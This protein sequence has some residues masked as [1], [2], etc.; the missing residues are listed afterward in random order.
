MGKRSLCNYGSVKISSPAFLDGGWIPSEYTQD[1]TNTVVPLD[2]T[3]IPATAQSLAITMHDPDVPR[4]KYPDDIFDHWV[5]WNI[6]V[7]R[8]H[9]RNDE[10]GG[11]T[12]RSTAGTNAW[13]GPGPPAGH[14]PHR[15]FFTAYALDTAL[16][17]EMM[18][19]TRAALEQAIH[20]NVLDKAVLIG[21]YERT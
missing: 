2:I 14:G 18:S 11:L 7:D 15:Y 1:G 20:G 4:G 10:H 19:T 17:L 13:Y 16:E 21:R 6:P 9:I 5:A 12:G 3:D 8:A